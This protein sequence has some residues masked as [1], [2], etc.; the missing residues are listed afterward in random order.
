M[1]YPFYLFKI[2]YSGLQKNLYKPCL[3]STLSGTRQSIHSFIAATKSNV[4]PDSN[5]RDTNCR[6]FWRRSVE[7]TLPY[8]RSSYLRA[9][10]LFDIIFIFVT[11]RPSGSDSPQN[12]YARLCQVCQLPSIRRVI[13]PFVARSAHTAHRKCY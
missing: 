13:F 1:T 6:Y 9:V 7:D 5:K 8:R 12:I 2:M 3:G 4:F 10:F 11:N